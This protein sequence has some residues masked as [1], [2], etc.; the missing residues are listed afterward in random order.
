MCRYI[1]YLALII[2]L[3]ASGAV[4]SL[5]CDQPECPAIVHGSIPETILLPFPEDCNKFITCNN[6]VQIVE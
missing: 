2:S 4:N 3:H 6:G 5:K 1:G